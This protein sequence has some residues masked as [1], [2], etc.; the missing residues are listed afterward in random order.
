MMVN[1]TPP[2]AP[3]SPSNKSSITL[4]DSTGCGNA[5]DSNDSSKGFFTTS[6]DDSHNS[7]RNVSSPEQKR[8]IEIIE[9]NFSTNG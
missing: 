5:A 1:N 7:T 9:K 8:K 6:I 4:I 3:S 2:S